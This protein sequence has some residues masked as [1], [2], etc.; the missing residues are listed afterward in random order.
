MIRNQTERS[1]DCSRD[2]LLRI[3]ATVLYEAWK[4]IH[5]LYYERNPLY[6]PF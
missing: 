3:V 6:F 4:N 2:P 1:A 5:C